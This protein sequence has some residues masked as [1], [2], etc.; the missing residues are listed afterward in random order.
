M[1]PILRCAAALL[2]LAF[3]L[4]GVGPAAAAQYLWQVSSVTN[5]VYLYGTVHAGMASWYPLPAEVEDAFEGSHILAVEADVTDDQAM[6]KS[7]AATVYTPPA[8]LTTQVPAEDYARFRRLLPRYQLAEET[9]VRVKPFMAATIVVFS[10]WA[11]LG[12][13][14]NY[15]VDLYFITRAKDEKKQIVELEGVDQQI[16]LMDSLTNDETLELFRGITSAVESGLAAEQVQGL[17]KAWQAGDANGVLD[18]ARRYDEKVPGAA[19]FEEKFI[20]SR[21]DAMIQ[22][23]SGYLDR[24][25]D[26]YFIAVGALHLAGPRGLV[27]LLRKKGYVVKQL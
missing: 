16:K 14:P 25:R 10:E 7:Q 22:K 1:N 2:A 19:A 23:I 26:R 27:E 20:W 6:K 21:H 18:V 24:G 3:G 5:R 11:R 15:G 9:M 17:V 8:N 13:T 12:Y 4:L